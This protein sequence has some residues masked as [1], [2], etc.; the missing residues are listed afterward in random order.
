M[1]GWHVARVGCAGPLH[2]PVWRCAGG[3]SH[4]MHVI[5]GLYW[6]GCVCVLG[7]LHW[8]ALGQWHGLAR[9]HPM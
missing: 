2:V 6:T 9:V 4:P 7:V 8:C 1:P 3:G 5:C